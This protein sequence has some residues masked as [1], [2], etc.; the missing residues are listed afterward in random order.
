MHPLKPT[1]RA[2]QKAESIGP[3]ELYNSQAASAYS[4]FAFLVAADALRQKSNGC[5]RFLWLNDP[6]SR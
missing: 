2:R 6:S 4:R 5:S 1:Q 3:D